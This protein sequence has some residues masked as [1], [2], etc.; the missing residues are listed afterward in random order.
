MLASSA[1]RLSPVFPSLATAHLP[2]LK[3]SADQRVP[4]SIRQAPEWHHFFAETLETSDLGADSRISTHILYRR[5]WVVP[6]SLQQPAVSLPRNHIRYEDILAGIFHPAGERFFE[7]L[8]K[9]RR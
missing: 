2:R 8:V 5:V 4:Q 6:Q 9:P 1:S 7:I 3:T